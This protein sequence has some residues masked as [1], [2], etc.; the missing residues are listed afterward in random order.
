MTFLVTGGAGFIGSALVHSLLNTTKDT[1][2][3][4]DNMSYASSPR[5]INYP[6]RTDKFRFINGNIGDAATVSQ[7][8]SHYKPAAIF[9]L[10][11][12]THVDR[13]IEIPSSFIDTNVV[14][15]SILLG[16]CLKYWRALGDECAIQFRFHHISTDEVY[17]SAP[18]PLSFTEKTAYDPKSPYSATKA[19]ADH[20][21]RA[22]HHTYGLPTLITNCS[23]NYGPR[24]FPEK[25][26]P[27]VINRALL[28]APLPIYGDGLHV[29]DWLFVDDHVSAIRTVLDRA[30]P[31]S[32]YNIG[33]EQPLANISVVQSICRTLD[34]LAPKENGQPYE[35]LITYVQDRPGH[36][37]RYSVDSSKIRSEFGWKPATRFDDGLR[38]TV[39]WYLENLDW[40]GHD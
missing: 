23:N 33:A 8:L 19:A 28:G 6:N 9:N 14:A 32:T 26:I 30:T 7:I 15:T 34:Q 22:W 27:L 17:G 39:Q 3:V 18:E 38:I 13:S 37:R 24:Q 31:G 16:E 36:D 10:A 35:D 21:V 5:S 11:A 20:L 40:W 4:L 25:L 29:R 12:E 1:V 2:V